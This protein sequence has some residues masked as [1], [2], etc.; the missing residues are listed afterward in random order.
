MFKKTLFII[1]LTVAALFSNSAFA[2]EDEDFE[3]APISETAET[4]PIADNKAPEVVDYPEEVIT[5]SDEASDD[6]ESAGETFW[7]QWP[8]YLS[9]GAIV[10]TFLLIIIIN[11]AG[12]KKRK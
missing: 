5:P 1:T 3:V 7:E 2:E 12:R 4:A 11:L 10:I 8:V 9:L 6:T